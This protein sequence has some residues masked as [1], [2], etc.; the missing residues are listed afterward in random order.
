MNKKAIAALLIG[1]GCGGAG[2]LLTRTGALDRLETATW[3]WRVTAFARPGPATDRIRIILLDQESLNWGV[4]QNAWPWPWPREAYGA[5]LDFCRRG[6]AK[7]IACDV[8]FTE[9]SYLGEADDDLLGEAIARTPGFVG[10]VQLGPERADPPDP[11]ILS[12]LGL[13]GSDPR[14][15]PTQNIPVFESVTA[16]I[17]QVF[18][19]APRLGNVSGRPDDDGILRRVA[20]F[21][22]IGGQIVPSLGMTVFLA[23][24]ASGPEVPVSRSFPMDREGYSILRFRGGS[25]TH[26]T[27]SAAAVI[28]SEIRLKTGEGKPVLDPEEF[29]DAY[30]FFGFSA[31]GLLDLRPTPVGRV[32][33]GVEL[34]A[35]FLDNLLSGDLIRDPPAVAAGT[36]PFLMAFLAGLVLL[37]V[38]KPWASALTASACLLIPVALGFALYPAGWWWP[39]AGPWVSTLLAI[40]SA[41]LYNYST[42]GRQKAFIKSAFRHYLS[43]LVIDRILEDPS[44]L[45]LGGERRE[46][47]IFFSDLQ[48]FSSLSEKLDPVRLTTLLNDYLSDM[49]GIILE[50]GGTLDKYEG[51]AILAF[52]NAPLALPDHAVRAVRAGLRCQR[53]LAERRGEFEAR[54]GVAL[55]MRIGIHTGDVVVGNMGSRERFDYTIL[56]DAA[57]LASRLEGANKVFG[58][59]FMVSETTWQKT[60]GAFSGRELAR[61]RVVGRQAPVRVFEPLGEAHESVP[62]PMRAFTDALALY[63]GGDRQAAVIAFEKIAGQDPAAQAYARRC[64]EE[65][66]GAAAED[67]VWTLSSK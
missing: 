52:W 17:R 39:V 55:H 49:T 19:A 62:G 65:M 59:Y 23:D 20:P 46:L 56:G 16:P 38:R 3:A 9:P 45:K 6:G 51:D 53:K 12:K 26:R 33:P 60:E 61:L 34:H 31:P 32:Y 18:D 4:E 64:R 50:E 36:A 40:G 10:A 67:G 5:I 22:R 63:A 11:E 54:S 44:Q 47:S 37:I 42:E 48:G 15:L 7:A 30:V 43:P 58:T 13:A 57:N 14:P 1:V 41:L 35:T 28:Q 66:S 2:F 8:L 25:G 29:R 24:P 27:V 21:G